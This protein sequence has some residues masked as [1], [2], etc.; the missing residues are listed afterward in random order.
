MTNT[1]NNV[2]NT[3]RIG[4]L[5]LQLAL[6]SFIGMF[7]YGM[8]NVINTIFVG[9]YVG[10]LGIAG[11]SIVFP[12]Q[13]LIIGFGMMVG[14][15][16]ASLI[17]RQLGAGDKSG[18]EKTLGNSISITIILSILIAILVIPFRDFW[19][20]LIGASDDVLPYAR[21][22]LVIIFGGA[23]FGIFAQ[24]SLNLARAEGNARVGMIA[25]GLGALISIALSALFIINLEMG[26]RGA[27]LAT[28]MAQMASVI[29]M[30]SY[31]LTRSS[32]LRL[33]F[34]NLILNLKT[35]K[36]IFAIGI[37]AFTQTVAGSLSLTI[38][39]NLVI[40][41]G[42][43]TALS[44]FGII[45]RVQFFA[46][47]PGMIIGQGAQPI[48]GYNHGAKNYNL[49]L[50]TIKIA[51]IWS[52]V[53]SLFAFI[54]MYSMPGLITR[55]FTTN[56]EV[57]ASGT[58]FLRILSISLPFMGMMHLGMQMF[59]ATGRAIQSFITAVAGPVVIIPLVLLMGH[60]WQLNGV[61][62]ASPASHALTFVLVLLL[63]MPFIR[64]YRKMATSESSGPDSSPGP[65]EITAPSEANMGCKPGV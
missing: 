39:L 29:Y 54:L 58:H 45:Q 65:K 42:G 53:V 24:A 1:D 63:V 56:T 31:Y 28:V 52:T 11:L 23:F 64:Q 49:L 18:A 35:L 47:M 19:L 30:L 22:Y 51:A 3:D 46:V 59:Q 25:Q 13:M 2:L 10:H 14:I 6:P 17:S 4:P 37:A 55:I 21:D 44:A 36:D 34:R 62:F 60:I 15:G 41:Y 16:G 48:L 32:Y 43:D 40:T 33:T 50:K 9:H 38:L 57:V 12:L 20:T 8:Y 27:A 61:L 5:L 26:V 7:V